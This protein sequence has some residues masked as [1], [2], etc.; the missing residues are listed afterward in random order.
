MICSDTNTTE[1]Y[2]KQN[3]SEKDIIKFSLI[4]EFRKERG[5]AGKK[6][7][8]QTNKH[9]CNCKERAESHLR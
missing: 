7:E 1:Y 6:R 4:C 2:T 9:I 3:K 8:R 5:K